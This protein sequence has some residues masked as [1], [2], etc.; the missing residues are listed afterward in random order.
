MNI[1]EIKLTDEQKLLS[2]IFHQIIKEKELIELMSLQ[3]SSNDSGFLAIQQS[4]LAG[5]KAESKY[6]RD[7][8]QRLF[9]KTQNL[10]ILKDPHDFCL[11]PFELSESP[12]LESDTLEL[13]IYERKSFYRIDDEIQKSVSQLSQKDEIISKLKE[14]ISN[15]EHEKEDI[16]YHLEDEIVILKH[17][18]EIYKHHL[19]SMRNEIKH[20]CERI[21]EEE[22]NNED[23]IKNFQALKR[24][25]KDLESEILGLLNNLHEKEEKNSKSKDLIESFGFT[26]ETSSIKSIKKEKTEELLKANENLEKKI[27]KLE[28]K[29]DS[30]RLNFEEKYNRLLSLYKK[31]DHDK[32]ENI[33]KI[34]DLNSEI[35]K[36]KQNL[37]ENENKALISS[38][39]IQDGLIERISKL[40]Q[41]KHALKQ[42]LKDLCSRD[43]GPDVAKN[44]VS[45]KEEISQSGEN[46]N[47]KASLVSIVDNKN[48]F[49]DNRMLKEEIEGLKK[50][51]EALQTKILSKDDEIIGLKSKLRLSLAKSEDK[52]SVFSI[53]SPRNSFF[54]KAKANPVVLKLFTKK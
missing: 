51:L 18:I 49:E 3:I 38:M 30:Q 15:H 28:N 20:L 41:E 19:K 44:A 48:Y 26:N 27:R 43:F 7:Y 14:T 24:K 11:N 8:I 32:K 2:T 10:S 29:N 22:K 16:V 31:A 5:L 23:L 35:L 54:G 1:E 47:L 9:E 42:R 6:L 40:K 52:K 50:D 4:T 17:Q 13:N 21:T 46:F 25:N 37:S 53:L 36:L 39:K 45:L 34:N 33:E 12:M